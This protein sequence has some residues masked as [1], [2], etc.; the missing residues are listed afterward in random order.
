MVGYRVRQ[1]A[2]ERTIIGML[3][4]GYTISPNGSLIGLVWAFFD[5]VV[6]GIVFACPYSRLVIKIGRPSEPRAH[7]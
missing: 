6:G 2:G 7:R 1:G 5:G 4:R 3:Y